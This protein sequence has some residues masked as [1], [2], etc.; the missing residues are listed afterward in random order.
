MLKTAAV[1]EIMKKRPVQ[2]SATSDKASRCLFGQVSRSVY[3]QPPPGNK[4]KTNTTA[5]PLK[6]PP[7]VR[8]VKR[9]ELR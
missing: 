6:G 2:G 5:V 8:H 7:C 9:S 4:T 1:I 3:G